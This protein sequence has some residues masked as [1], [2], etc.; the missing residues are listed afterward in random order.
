MD[1]EAI[2]SKFEEL[3]DEKVVESNKRFAIEYEYS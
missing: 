3:Q 2:I 1:F